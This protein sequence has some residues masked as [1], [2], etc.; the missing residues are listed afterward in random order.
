[1]GSNVYRKFLKLYS[2][3]I[4]LLMISMLLSSAAL[5]QSWNNDKNSISG[6]LQ[7]VENNQDITKSAVLNKVISVKM[8]S[9]TVLEA[10][11]EVAHQV[12]LELIYNAVDQET[13]SYKL[14]MIVEEMTFNQALCKNIDDTGI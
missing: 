14:T 2:S 10:L 6:L 8:G 7:G 1:M 11:E 3:L 9:A 13:A 4:S 5:G 12:E